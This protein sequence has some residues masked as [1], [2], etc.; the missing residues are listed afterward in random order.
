MRKFNKLGSKIKCTAIAGVAALMLAGCG[1]VASVATTEAATE[2][3][4]AATTEATPE[5]ETEA[6]TEAATE[7]ETEADAGAS[8]S[9]KAEK[10]SIEE[11]NLGFGL[12]AK[13][14][15]DTNKPVEF[16][17]YT[18]NIP[19]YYGEAVDESATTHNV[20]FYPEKGTSVA[21]LQLYYNDVAATDAQFKEYVTSDG[22]FDEIT[23][24]LD[25]I[26]YYSNTKVLY[27][28]DYKVAGKDAKRLVI[29]C[30]CD[31]PGTDIKKIQVETFVFFDVDAQKMF[32]IEM[33]SS[34]NVSANYFPDFEKIIDNISK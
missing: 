16:Q 34:D 19:D 24:S 18:F 2:A 28:G 31:M 5:V 8:G 26:Q 12:E 11:T 22:F 7:A 20:Y 10:S 4:T 3:T 9:S 27:C 23:T 33:F 6:E 13:N 30:D 14:E 32:M 29:E 21:M 17:S 15:Y 1:D 25:S